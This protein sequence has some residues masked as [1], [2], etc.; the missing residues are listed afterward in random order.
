MR[1]RPVTQ[2]LLAIGLLA[3]AG[4]GVNGS[5]QGGGTDNGSYGHVKVGVP[6]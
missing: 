1:K 3:L 4:C 5:A 2:T 6:F